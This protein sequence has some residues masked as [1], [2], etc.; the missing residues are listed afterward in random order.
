MRVFCCASIKAWL[1]RNKAT[2]PS[3]SF[4]ADG[5]DGGG[6]GAMPKTRLSVCFISSYV[7]GSVSESV[8]RGVSMTRPA[9]E[10]SMPANDQ[11]RTSERGTRTSAV[12][13]RPFHP[14]VAL[15]VAG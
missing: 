13:G 2:Q 7:K 3:Y 4:T 6:F 8:R 15:S 11:E 10:R 9:N 12:P 14:S 5:G 1:L